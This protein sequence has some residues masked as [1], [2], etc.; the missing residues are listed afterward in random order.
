MSTMMMLCIGNAIH[1]EEN[2]EVEGKR[3]KSISTTEHTKNLQN[4]GFSVPH[5]GSNQYFRATVSF[6]WHLHLTPHNTLTTET[7]THGIG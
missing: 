2:R 4:R 1:V 7:Q 6:E 3:G 5:L